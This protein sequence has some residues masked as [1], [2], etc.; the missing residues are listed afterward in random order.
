MSESVSLTDFVLQEARE[1]CFE[2][3]IKGFKAYESE[4][5][6]IIAN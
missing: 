4:K 6:K 5:D 1:K 2:L 3:D